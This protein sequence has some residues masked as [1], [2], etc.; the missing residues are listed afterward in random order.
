VNV[1]Y[2]YA[3]S[4]NDWNSSE[5][6]CAIPARAINRLGGH[7]AGL[8][9]ILDFK[10]NSDAARKTCAEAD[11]IVVQRDLSAPTQSAIEHWQRAG[12]A[13]IADF[14]DAFNFLEPS[15][16]INGAYSYWILGRVRRT[17]ADGKPAWVKINPPPL[18]QFKKG[19][20]MVDAATV[21]SRLLADDWRDYAPIHYLPNYIEA[22]RYDVARS[23]P[24]DGIILGWGG[25]A[26]HLASFA[27]SN[28]LAALE[29]VCRDRRDV[30]VMICGND[31]RILQALR[32]PPA[33]KIAALRLLRRV[34]ANHRQLR[35]RARPVARCI[36]RSSQ[37][38]QGARVPGRGH[39]LDCQ[40]RAR[41][42]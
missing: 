5:W 12:K 33:Q 25:S 2:V 36:R 11:V 41:I 31:P 23:A 1:L 37:L 27:E 42:R 29:S 3:D 38:D 16:D 6:R 39:S 17:G 32:I 22:R 18:A 21:S 8:L 30:R 28:I 26:T 24:H 13:V 19:L 9:S 14:D 15:N 4:V 7:A 20:R 10:S 40:S 35:H 34:A